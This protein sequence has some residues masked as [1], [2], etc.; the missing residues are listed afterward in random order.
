MAGKINN[1]KSE[2]KKLRRFQIRDIETKKV[3]ESFNNDR[4]AMNYLV[5]MKFSLDNFYEIYDSELDEVFYVKKRFGG[6]GK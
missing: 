2:D 4:S 3:R 1:M 5:S 6:R